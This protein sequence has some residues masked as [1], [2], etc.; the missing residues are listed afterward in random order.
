ML[1][2]TSPEALRTTVQRQEI[3]SRFECSVSAIAADIYYLQR[4]VVTGIIYALVDP[5][6][7]AVRYV[8]RTIEARRRLIGH[9]NGHANPR[10]RAWVMELR[11]VGLEPRMVTLEECPVRQLVDR[12]DW[13]I[14]EMR[15]R[16]AD[17]TNAVEAR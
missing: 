2:D 12:E 6:S 9:R 3:A 15:R 16:G 17:L 14:K 7:D 4:Q 11:T 1:L 8:G 13:W 5:R 10:E